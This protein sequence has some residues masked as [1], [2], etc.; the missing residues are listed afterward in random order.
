MS[1]FTRQDEF[2]VLLCFLDHKRRLVDPAQVVGGCHKVRILSLGIQLRILL[3]SVEGLLKALF[4][5]FQ[6]A[7]PLDRSRPCLRPTNERSDGGI[8]K[9]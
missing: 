6:V 5:F 1:A 9:M 4:G 8:P 3:G 2:V 7:Q